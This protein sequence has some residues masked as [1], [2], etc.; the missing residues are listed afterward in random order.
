VLLRCAIQLSICSEHRV[1]VASG[2][3]PRHQHRIGIAH[4]AGVRHL[5]LTVPSPG[6]GELEAWPL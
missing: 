5:C 2:C 3:P 6:N 1:E 4:G